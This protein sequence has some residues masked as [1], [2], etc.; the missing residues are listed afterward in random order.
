MNRIEQKIVLTFAATDTVP[1]EFA[2]VIQRIVFRPSV[3]R[4]LAA[5]DTVPFKFALVV[6]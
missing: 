4:I 3:C 6:Q 5:T 2:L 1:F